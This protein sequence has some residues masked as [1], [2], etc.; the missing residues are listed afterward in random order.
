MQ[1]KF[2]N[3]KVFN[4]L[5][6]ND[7][8]HKSNMR[9]TMQNTM[10]HS[11]RCHSISSF[12]I[13]HLWRGA[14]IT[15]QT[16]RGDHSTSIS[17]YKVWGART[18][19]QISKRELHT[20]IHL[21]YVRIEILYCKNKKKK[22]KLSTLNAKTQSNGISLIASLASI[23][24]VSVGVVYFITYSLLFLWLISTAKKKKKSHRKRLAVTASYNRA[25]HL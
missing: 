24:N 21:D 5:T 14:V 1:G 11:H 8:G 10:S 16:W 2:L 13:A 22:K 25:A 4:E 19:I 15:L 7:V 18:E 20:H 6:R 3:P 23:L 12:T 17:A 9:W